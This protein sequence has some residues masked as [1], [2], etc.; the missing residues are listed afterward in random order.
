M[1]NSL[2]KLGIKSF[3]VAMVLFFAFMGTEQAKAQG[4]GGYCQIWPPDPSIN[5]NYQYC[6]SQYY[7]Y[8]SEMEIVDRSSG[9]V[10]YTSSSGD[11][12]CYRFETNV[13][14]LK[15]GRN[16]TVNLTGFM[17]YGMYSYEG[18][19][20]FFIDYNQNGSFNDAT[21]YIG[22]KTEYSSSQTRKASFNFSVGCSVQPGQTRARALFGYYYYNPNSSDA[23][24]FGYKYLSGTYN[25]TYVYGEGEDYLLEFIP[26]I[27]GQFP[28]QN[29]IL[30]VNTD[31]NGTNGNPKPFARMGSV[32]P[33]GTILNYR[34][35]GPRPSEDMVYE[36]L[37]PATGSPN[38]NMGGYSQYNMLRARG[39]YAANG[40]DGTFRGTRGGEYKLAIAVSG[41]GCPGA[42]YASFTVSWPNDMAASE[43]V[44][45]RSNGA[46]SFYKYPQG[47]PIAVQAV[48][49]NTGV[50]PV[51]EFTAYCYL[52]NSAGDTV[53]TYRYDYDSDIH[54]GDVTLNAT[55]KATINFG[56]IRVNNVGIYK[57]YLYVDLL[58]AVDQEAFNDRLPRQGEAAYTFEVAYDIQLQAY[59]V[60]SPKQGEVVIGNRPIIPRGTFKNH[61]IYDA[62][63]VPARL[64]IYKLPN[65][66]TPVYTSSI[67]VQDIPAGRYNSKFEQ[68]DLMILRESGTYQSE[69]IISHPDDQIR[70]DDTT[71]STF[72]VEGGLM[73]TYTVGAGGNFPTIDSLMNKLYQRGLAGDC[74]FLFTDSYYQVKGTNRENAAWDFTTYIINLGWNA[75]EGRAY[76]ITFKPSQQKSLTKGSVTIELMSPN[77]NGVQFGQSMNPANQNS[78]YYQYAN[79]G[80]IA[81]NYINFPG[82]VTFDGGSQKSLKFKVTSYSRGTAN[83]F[84]L[85][86]GTEN[87][88]IKNVIIENNTPTLACATWLP[89]TSYNPTNGFQ[90]QADTLL[91]GGVVSGYSAG[92]VNR[93]TLFGTEQAQIMRV[94]TIPNTNNVI[95][96]N[97][98]KGFGYGIVSLGIG[99]LLLENEGDYARFYNKSNEISNNKI[100]DVCRTGVFVG[101]EEETEVTGNRIYNVTNNNGATAGIIAGGNGTSTYKG[102]NNVKLSILGNEVSDIESGIGVTGIKIEQAQNVYQHPSLGQVYF[103][104]VNEETKV[105]NNAV[106]GLTTTTAGAPRAGIHLYTERGANLWT[107]KAGTYHTRNDEI[108]NNTVV[109]AG[110]GGVSSTGPVVAFGIQSGMWTIFKNNAIALTDMGVDVTSPAY[111]GLLYQ[112]I[113]PEDGGLTSDNNVYY[114]S[115]GSNGA[116]AYFIEAD[117]DGNNIEVGGRYDYATMDQWRNWTGADFKSVEGNFL[118][119][120]E[121]TGT[122][123]DQRL[124]VKL[125]P[126]PMG[127]ILNN[128]GE[129]LP[130]V[131]TD[132]TG[133]TRGAAGQNYDIGHDEFEGRLYLSDV[134][135]LFITAP[136]AYQSGS[137]FFSDAEYVMTT[138]PVEIEGLIRNSGNLP[139]NSIELTVN[140]Y[141]ELPNGIFSTVPEL[142]T[143]AI[144]S[145]QSGVTVSVPFGLSNGLAPDFAPR[146]YAELREMGE[147]YVPADEFMSMM[148]NVTPKY[149][150]V[151]GI[152]ADQ[153]NQNNYMEKIVRFYI[154]KSDMRI[155]AS[156][157]NSMAVLDQNS[158]TDEIAGRLNAD[159]L[160]KAFSQLGWVID[161]DDARYDYDIFDRA[162]WEAKAVDYSMYRTMW[163]GDASDKPLTRYQRFDITDFLTLGNQ[164]EKK[165]LIISSQDMV[166]E[167][168]MNNIY[169]DTYFTE[170]ILRS[171]YAAPGNPLGIGGNND[172]NSVIGR[173]LHR[174]VEEE[175]AST[176]YAGDDYPETGLVKVS[177]TGE[178][179]SMGTAYYT[180]H[181]GAPSDSLSGVATTTLNRNV[182]YMGIDWR[183]WRT[184]QYIVRAS[185][186]FI[187]KNGGTIIPVELTDFDARAIGRRVELNWQTA[188]EYNSDKF[189]IERTIKSEAGA[190]I[191]TKIGEEKAAGTS[192]EP[193]V[194]GPIVDRNVEMGQTYAYRLKMVDLTG[195]YEYSEVREVKIGE[196]GGAWLGESMPNPIATTSEIEYSAQGAVTIELYDMTGKLVQVLFD[197]TVNGAGVLTLDASQLTSG[198]YNVVLKSAEITLTRNINVVK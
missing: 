99:Q 136:A 2:T 73:G 137:G 114:T 166:R 55:Q 156:V 63:D 179:L 119:D 110:N 162:G 32:Q 78:I 159:S 50:N 79:Y 64:N 24:N 170:E 143:T 169:E 91:S 172:G 89:M 46:P 85:G 148:A 23:C 6:Y 125:N 194:Y 60:T 142:T 3:L 118:A 154:R 107:P 57:V 141:R 77:G 98:I 104:D 56:N 128:R 173:A 92:I 171:E 93:S 82:Y 29:D 157:E 127:S 26:D 195:E 164:I 84:Y 97:E 72:T 189:E 132:I 130:W 19:W 54:P 153:Y 190:G 145:A 17:Y 102:Y 83:A 61:G 123:P 115:D 13:A 174:N 65:L 71:R 124:R 39:D 16:Y 196:D 34:I 22:Y 185:I 149:K 5:W 1:M 94:D 43:V 9:Q 25:Y 49:Q 144:T 27:D 146:T 31:Y 140:V 160:F 117:E 41:S 133:E 198:R 42:S 180:D 70:S 66:V 131:T 52:V 87:V 8:I 69:M 147:P 103:P 44:S 121:Y 20:R 62:S 35:T 161:L 80:S 86:R 186:D 28:E 139:Q 88:T 36:G 51:T 138:A 90:F 152:Q 58:S 122:A 40:G 14:Q 105:A 192:A 95:S 177:R 183:H 7:G 150:I 187:E 193:R 38:I 4:P 48:F 101:Y 81:R 106:W 163:W 67:I 126:A 12:Y 33:A 129:K 11:D 168:S 53:G 112:G 134:E 158:T 30:S 178:G 182:I 181:S 96:G 45:P 109:I 10:V 37:D 191:F 18:S 111:A 155:V 120:M 116:F 74:I 75:D 167:H 15:I 188:S 165:N 151:I 184:A 108:A 59:E 76:T 113:M 68:F 176:G 47:I 135:A 21:E 175:I 100:Y 197:G